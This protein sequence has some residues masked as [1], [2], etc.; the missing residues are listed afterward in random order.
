MLEELSRPSIS[1][2]DEH[3]IEEMQQQHQ[4]VEQGGKQERYI[5]DGIGD[6]DAEN[7]QDSDD[8][9]GKNIDS[10]SV[11]YCKNI[12]DHESDESENRDLLRDVGC[13]LIANLPK[14]AAPRLP[15]SALIGAFQKYQQGSHNV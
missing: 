14:D 8:S 5:G 7:D 2:L 6:G 9:N 1:I 3:N 12:S 15:S 10:H 11:D 4:E 13:L